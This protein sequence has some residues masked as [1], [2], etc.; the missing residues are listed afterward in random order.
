M[1]T[2]TCPETGRLAHTHAGRRAAPEP[3][4]VKQ[5]FAELGQELSERLESYEVRRKALQGGEVQVAPESLDRDS[6]RALEA[7]GYLESEPN[8]DNSETSMTNEISAQD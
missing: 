2:T 4:S 1:P 6:R 7:L 5:T 8:E 3:A